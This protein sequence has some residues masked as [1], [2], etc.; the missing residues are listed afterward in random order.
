[1]KKRLLITGAN[2][3]LG[4]ALVQTY[5][6]NYEVYATGSNQN[7]LDY[8]HR[9]KS[10]DLEEESYE[11][12]IR[13]SQPDV[14]IHCAALTDGNH[15]QENIEQAFKINSFSLKKFSEILN[16]SCRLIYI[17]TDAVFPSDLHLAKE[18]SCRNAESVYGKSKE[19]GEFFLFNSEINFSV[20]RTTIVGL[21]LDRNKKGFVEWII[22]SAINKEEISLFDDVVFTPIATWQLAENLEVLFA[23]DS[24]FSRKAVHI[25][26]NEICTKY[27]FGIQL[28][29]ALKL[30]V[31]KVNKG[32]IS[33]MV[34]RAKRSNDQ[35]LNCSFFQKE[36]NKTL[37][38]LQETIEFIKLNYTNYEK[39]Q[40]R[41]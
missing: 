33:R 18:D 2:G 41:K 26:G 30:P 23:N 16:I 21:N 27:E 15:C 39:H 38:S 11:N 17:S 40:T 14:V 1:M 25:S 10:F 5:Q 20:V 13:W 7:G 3:M 8:F 24:P 6:K 4:S 32:V 9:Y 36:S 29:K 12:L 34:G 31:D 35:T 37:P 28:L 19:L 22:N